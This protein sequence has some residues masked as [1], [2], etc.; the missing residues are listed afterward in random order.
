MKI[1]IDITPLSVGK[2]GVPRYTQALVERLLEID[3]ENEYTLFHAGPARS[4]DLTDASPR[5]RVKVLCWQGRVASLA[6]MA[7]KLP[8]PF[9]SAW[10][11]TET[12]L[13]RPQRKAQLAGLDVFHSSDVFL[14]DNRPAKN[15]VTMFDITTV[16]FPEFHTK[17]NIRLHDRKIAFAK[18]AVHKIVAISECTKDDLVKHCGISPDRIKVIYPGCDHRLFRVL[19]EDDVPAVL[20]TYG[21]TKGYI[22]F[23]STI[24]PRKNVERL[25]EAFEMLA[26]LGRPSEQLVLI[27]AKGW[28]SAKIYRRIENSPLRDQITWLGQMPEGDLPYLYNGAG[29]LAYPSIYEGFGLPVVEAMACG[30]P[31]VATN[32]SSVPEIVG[33]TGL[34]VSPYDV[35]GL[36]EAMRRL[37]VDHD[38]RHEMTEQAI[39]RAQFFSWEKTAREMLETYQQVIGCSSG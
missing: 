23:V 35:E 36:A 9:R 12:A 30:V 26:R 19:A 33:D 20:R 27:G 7:R 11:I 37:L 38:L 22:L 3:A 2:G 5:P 16:L 28:L 39:A 17:A 8:R 25:V 10:M 21:L 29:L 34:L 24:E 1:G 18:E 14:W 31:V 13:L 6:L 4:L 32:T 15:I